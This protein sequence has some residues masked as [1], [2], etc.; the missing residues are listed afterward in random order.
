MLIWLRKILIAFLCVSPLTIQCKD[1]SDIQNQIQQQEKR[2]ADQKREQNKLQS[3]LQEQELRIDHIINQLNKTSEDLKIINKKI[4]ETDTQIKHLEQQEKEQKEKLA[5]QLDEMYRLNHNTSILDKLLSEKA[6]QSDRLMRYYHYINQARVDLIKDLKQTQHYLIAHKKDIQQ[7]YNE[8][9]HYLN[10][11]TKY[12][13]NLQKIQQERRTTLDKLNITLSQAQNKL[14][15]LK[16]N[17]AALRL[18]IQHAEQKTKEQEKRER[19]ILVLDQPHTNNAKQKP[20]VSTKKEKQLEVNHLGLG[21]PQKQYQYPTT[22]KILNQFGSTQMGEL[23]WKGI[24]IKADSGKPVKAIANGR[25]I[26]ANWLQGYGL[27]IIIK[28]GDH[29]LSLYGYNQSISVKEGEFVSAGQK[30]AEVG[31]TGGQA[32]SGLYFEIRRKGIPVN[33]IGWL[34]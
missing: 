18:Q 14:N 24:V 28:H 27:M 23:K 29:D 2:I 25:V 33:P 7:Q 4:A 20:Y 5:K 6:Q 17:E 3:T 1:L 22:G 26:L 32:N 11:Q 9:Q 15:E 16:N 10:E 21:K 19:E 31:A 30:I 12:Q 13:L 34:K 8:Q